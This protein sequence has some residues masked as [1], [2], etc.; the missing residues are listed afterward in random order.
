MPLPTSRSRALN[1]E[2]AGLRGGSGMCTGIRRRVARRAPL[3]ALSS[4]LRGCPLRLRLPARA[5]VHERT[6]QTPTGLLRPD[7]PPG[8]PSRAPGALAIAGG[9]S[10][11]VQDLKNQTTM[12]FREPPTAAAAGGRARSEGVRRQEGGRG[13][14]R[15]SR[16]R[17]S[18]ARG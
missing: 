7:R 9:A 17:R 5:R 3:S 13:R 12:H 1:E 8:G 11:L 18:A 6:A 15:R 16:R 2:S 4:W 14:R 10:T